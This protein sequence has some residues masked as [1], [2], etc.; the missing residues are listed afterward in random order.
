MLFVDYTFDLLPGG[1]I[2]FFEDLKPS[3]INVKDGDEF[4]LSIID[5]RI[6]FVKKGK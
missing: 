5:E 2:R 6:T 3:D 1:S 4:V